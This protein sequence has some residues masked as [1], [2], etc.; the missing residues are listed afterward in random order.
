MASEGVYLKD[1]N[2]IRW[3]LE[4]DAGAS[5]R[6]NNPSTPLHMASRW[7]AVQVARILLEHGADIEAED[8]EAN[9]PLT[10]AIAGHQDDM[11]EFLLEHGAK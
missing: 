7:G 1:L 4:H 6:A 2:V 10:M 3:L 5:A 11:M 8:D 9:T